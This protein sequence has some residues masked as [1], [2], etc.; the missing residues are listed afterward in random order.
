[1]GDIF[2]ADDTGEFVPAGNVFQIPGAKDLLDFSALFVQL[3]CKDQNLLFLLLHI[4]LMAFDAVLIQCF[5]HIGERARGI[6]KLTA[7]MT[8][9]AKGA[10]D[11]LSVSFIL[12][13]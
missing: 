8:A 13:P 4:V 9:M 6:G 3:L 11:T 7:R 12:F 1:M 5:G 10:G 2:M